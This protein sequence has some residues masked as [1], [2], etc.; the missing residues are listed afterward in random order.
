MLSPLINSPFY[1]LPFRT[2]HVAHFPVLKPETSLPI[3]STNGTPRMVCQRRVYR[4]YT[5]TPERRRGGRGLTPPSRQTSQ[6]F[7]PGL[8]GLGRP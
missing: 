6:A 7:N 2:W 4:T 1:T 3:H 5:G 8:D